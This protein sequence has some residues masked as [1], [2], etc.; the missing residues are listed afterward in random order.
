MGAQ[1]R[2]LAW[3]QEAAKASWTRRLS[4]TRSQEHR[5]QKSGTKKNG[6]FQ[7][8][9]CTVGLVPKRQGRERK[10]VWGWRGRQGPEPT[11]F[12]Y[13]GMVWTSPGALH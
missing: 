10:W 8:Q 11:G 13:Q 5:K 6:V 7:E 4:E 12:P 9:M 2:Y 1:S 3:P